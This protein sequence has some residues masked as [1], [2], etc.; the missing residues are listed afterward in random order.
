MGPREIID[1]IRSTGTVT[2]GEVVRSTNPISIS[3]QEGDFLKRVISE[4]RNITSVLEIGFAYGLSTLYIADA[5]S[6]RDVE[7]Y[8][9]VDP[10][11]ST[12]WHSIGLRNIERAG[13]DYVDLME[14]YSEVALP[15]LLSQGARFDFVFIDGYHTFDHTLLD[16]FYANRLTDVG[17]LIVV[18]DCSFS[19]VA[20]AVSYFANYPC[21]EIAYEPDVRSVRQQIKAAARAM[22]PRPLAK[23]ILPHSVYA[24][25]YSKRIFPTM[26]ALRKVAEDNR[27]WRWFQSF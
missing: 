23:H 21:F 10:H 18:D 22:V 16:L 13:I 19:S 25:A 11:Q 15:N 27:D 5:L 20:M 12:Q 9:A 4:N 26:I 8:V 2:N 17:G 24:T 7:R 6:D 3:A 14:E 1:E